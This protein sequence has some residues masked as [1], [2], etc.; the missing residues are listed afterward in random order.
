M[1]ESYGDTWN[2]N[3][4]DSA[5]YHTPIRRDTGERDAKMDAMANTAARTAPL[6]EQL[7]DQ[8]RFVEVDD[9]IRKAGEHVIEF[10]DDDG[11]LRTEPDQ[12]VIRLDPSTG[13]R[14]VLNAQR[15][16]AALPGAVEFDVEFASKGGEGPTPY[17][18]LLQ[19]ALAGK[20]VR[21]GRQDTIEEAWRVMH[22][23]I[24]SPPPVH[25]YAPGSWGPPEA[26]ALVADYGG[27]RAPW[28]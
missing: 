6:G 8:W 25:R 2:Q 11:Y 5:E 21:F 19:A 20:R 17:E 1:S 14:I 22:P 7:V 28:L 18:V 16:D 3:T 23:L 12:I 15:A 13:V 10:I 27:W 9:V 24:Q 4:T 26:D